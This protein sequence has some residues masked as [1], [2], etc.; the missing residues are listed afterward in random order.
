MKF[1]VSINDFMQDVFDTGARKVW[2]QINEF[3]NVFQAYSLYYSQ[4][5]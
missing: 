1:F 5:A 2:C 4:P 3:A